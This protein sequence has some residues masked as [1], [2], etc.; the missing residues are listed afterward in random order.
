MVGY[1]VHGT[2]KP[3]SIALKVPRASTPPVVTLYTGR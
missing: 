2:A 3:G 1:P